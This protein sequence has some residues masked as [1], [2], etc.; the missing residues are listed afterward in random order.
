MTGTELKEVGGTGRES[1]FIV[2]SCSSEGSAAADSDGLAE[3][4]IARAVTW[5]QLCDLC[6][7]G[8]VEEVCG[9]GVETIVVVKTSPD[10]GSVSADGDGHLSSN[11]RRMAEQQRRIRHIKPAESFG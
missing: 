7:R 3:I 2:S 6:S 5:E 11:G 9:A 4:I 10:D 1:I 8:D